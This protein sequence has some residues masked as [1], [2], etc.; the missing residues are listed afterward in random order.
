[1]V[2]RS[3]SRL[4]PAS[5]TPVGSPE[6]MPCPLLLTDE[7]APNGFEQRERVVQ[8]VLRACARIVERRVERGGNHADDTGERTHAAGRVEASPPYDPLPCRVVERAR[9][10]RVQRFAAVMPQREAARAANL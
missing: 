9:R 8:V 10:G 6:S 4:R 3:S 1:M 5:A 7:R 2:A